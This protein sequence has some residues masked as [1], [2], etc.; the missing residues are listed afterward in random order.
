MDNNQKTLIAETM[1][2]LQEAVLNEQSL[3]LMFQY[4]GELTSLAGESFSLGFLEALAKANLG[5]GN[6][7]IDVYLSEVFKGENKG[8]EI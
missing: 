3:T 2:N 7:V 5:A 6:F 1:K 4:E 8:G